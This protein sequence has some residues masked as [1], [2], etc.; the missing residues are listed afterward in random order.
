[1]DLHLQFRSGTSLER[2]H[3]IAHALRAAIEAELGPSEVLIHVEPE[4]SFRPDQR[5]PLRAG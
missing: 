2:A 3:E 5:G 4:E 1:V